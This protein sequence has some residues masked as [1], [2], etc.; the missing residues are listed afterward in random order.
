MSALAKSE[1]WHHRSRGFTVA[2]V[3]WLDENHDDR[4]GPHRWNVYA[5][6][7]PAHPMFAAL[8]EGRTS[9]AVGALPLHEGETC[10][11]WHIGSDG[12]PTSLQIGSDY[13]HFNDERYTHMATADDARSVFA[14]ADRLVDYLAVSPEPRP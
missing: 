12:W 4:N 9:P 7:Y 6:V 8:A 5:Y 13:N 14:D 3:H 2:I 1:V 11:H 10:Y